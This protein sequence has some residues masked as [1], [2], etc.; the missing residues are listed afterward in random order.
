MCVCVCAQILRSGHEST[1]NDECSW[2][3]ICRLVL[4]QYASLSKDRELVKPEPDWLVSLHVFYSR[5]RYINSEET[6]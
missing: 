4:S 6:E 2:R 5:P 1:M 3:F